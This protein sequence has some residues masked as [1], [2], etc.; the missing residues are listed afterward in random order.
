[1]AS[2]EFSTG[3]YSEHSASLTCLPPGHLDQ[4]SRT[5]SACPVKRL[6]AVLHEVVALWCMGI[7]QS[8][9]LGTHRTSLR[10]HPSRCRFGQRPLCRDKRRRHLAPCT[11]HSDKCPSHTLQ[12]LTHK[13]KCRSRQLCTPLSIAGTA[14]NPTSMASG[15]RRTRHHR[16]PPQSNQLMACNRSFPGR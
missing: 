3:F 14:T 15:V 12:T 6:T 13:I 16:S 7:V 4:K 11:Q 1:M 8:V 2:N 5:G 9:C 10:V